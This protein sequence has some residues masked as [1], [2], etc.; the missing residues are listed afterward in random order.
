M[1][2]KI[3][4]K[5]EGQEQKQEDGKLQKRGLVDKVTEVVM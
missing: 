3:V 4:G 2:R 1:N 5:R